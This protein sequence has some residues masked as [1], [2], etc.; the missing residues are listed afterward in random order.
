MTILNLTQHPASPEQVQAGVVEPQDKAKVRELLTFN[1]I[2]THSQIKQTAE[3]LADLAKDHGAE[4]AMIG[5]ALFL[6]APLAQALR[7]RGITPLFAFTKR[8]VEEVTLPDGT[9]EKK[10]VFRHEGWVEAV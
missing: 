2:P 3:A 6:M 9:V 5:G 8:V 7:D 4:A 10:A 1:E